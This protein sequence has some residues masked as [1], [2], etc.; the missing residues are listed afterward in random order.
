MPDQLTSA[1]LQT[2][3]LAEIVAELVAY[4]QQI[5]G[6]DINVDP[7]SPDGQLINILAQVGIDRR[8]IAKEV[9]SSFGLDGAFG[10][11]LDQRV[12]LN[13]VTRIPGTYTYTPVSVTFDRAL[14]LKGL[15]G[16][17]TPAGDEFTVYD[18]EGNEFILATSQAIV[19]PSTNSYQFRAKDIGRVETTLNTITNQ[20]TIVIGV[21]AVNNPSPPIVIGQDE[22]TDAALRIRHAKMFKLASTGPAD[23]VR[24]ALLS[25]PGVFDAYVA[26]NVTDA[27]ANGLDPHS[28]WCIV[29]GGT[30][31]D[32]AQAIYS[33]K[34]PG[35]GLNGAVNVNVARPQG[36]TMT[37]LFDRPTAQNLHFRFTL[38]PRLPSLDFDNDLIKQKIV[39]TVSYKIAQLSSIGDFVIAMQTI[40]PDVIVTAPQVSLN[41]ADW[42]DYVNP[43]T[44][45]H[46]L[47]L[48]VARITIN[49]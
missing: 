10:K 23:A 1:G 47:V 39:E 27:V 41:G 6:S 24:A 28:I 37:I 18:N 7:N 29:D 45:Q 35:C 40:E 5:Y 36:N 21:T 12:S 2:K 25:T 4:F 38:V 16:V 11:A 42:S 43:P 9:Y 32:V 15:D 33:K 34:A 31:A 20:R 3:T 13:G 49:E 22:E 30:N 44:F 8:E 48:D 14:N 19:A 26:E 17:E 46:R